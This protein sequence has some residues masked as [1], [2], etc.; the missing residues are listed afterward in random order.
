MARKSKQRRCFT[1]IELLVVVAIIA[2]L[3]AIL[4]PAMASARESA[5]FAV[6]QSNVRQIQIGLTMYADDSDSFLPTVNTSALSEMHSLGLLYPK[7]VGGEKVFH[8]PGAEERD[9]KTVTLADGV[10]TFSSSYNYQDS[11]TPLPMGIPGLKLDK[12]YSDILPSDS[13]RS[14]IPLLCCD[15]V[16]F[17]ARV[18]HFANGGARFGQSGESYLW[19]TEGRL[20]MRF[21]R[22]RDDW[23]EFGVF[24]MYDWPY[25]PHF[26]AKT[27]RGW[28]HSQVRMWQ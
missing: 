23:P 14:G 6:D 27:W 24:A 1:L 12:V 9:L 11:T 3:V 5:K 8:C 10:T 15:N 22:I 21:E 25:Y 17:P 2:V 13:S 4:L 28:N 16:E 18:N 7:Y 26:V 19:L 20:E